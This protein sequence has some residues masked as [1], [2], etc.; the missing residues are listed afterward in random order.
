LLDAGYFEG[1]DVVIEW[2]NA[3]GDYNQLP[4]LAADLVQRKVELIVADGTVATRAAKRETS[5]I[6]IVII[7][8]S[9]PVGSGLV[10]SL[11]RPA[12]NV[13]GLTIMA[14]DLTAKRLQLLK[15]AIP[16]LT[17]L[18]VLWNPDTPYHPK[19]IE[20][21]KMA[22]RSLSIQ[23]DLVSART[24]GEFGTALS[25]AGRARAH[26]LYVVE[27]GLFFNGRTALVK[28]ASRGRLA[29][30]YWQRNF[31]EEGGLMSYGPKLSDLMRR[32]AAYVDKN[33]EGREASGSAD[34]AAHQ[35]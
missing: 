29:A 34:R 33:P 23:L 2:R 11:A 27:D 22:A 17:R 8:A 6:P 3:N 9:D 21:L 1:R 16:R 28:L 19:L 35:I 5:T 32:S 26:G 31:P 25:A 12:G 30:I 24:P 15:D 14:T 7:F 20:E 4:Q 18:A 13:T 10:A